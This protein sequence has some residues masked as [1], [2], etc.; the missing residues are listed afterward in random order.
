MRITSVYPTRTFKLIMEFEQKE[1][2]ILDVKE[3]LVEDSGLLAEIRDTVSIFITAKVDPV[4]GTVGWANG[5]DIDPLVLYYK[6]LD[7]EELLKKS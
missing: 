5:V 1:Y 6:S 2:R 7:L 3:L 4:A